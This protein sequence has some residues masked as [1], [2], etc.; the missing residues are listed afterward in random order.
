MKIILSISAV[1]GIITNAYF[2][3]K[4]GD[5]GNFVW[6]IGFAIFFLWASIPFVTL[7]YL[8][9]KQYHSPLELIPLVIAALMLVFSNSKI[10]YMAFV[11]HL[12]PQ[13]GLVFIFLPIY[14]FLFLSV[15]IGISFIIKKVLTRKNDGQ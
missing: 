12:D 11:T 4:A 8:S 9:K 14:Q 5:V 3:I 10:L 1:F 15:F 6:W 2:M 13:S 7:F